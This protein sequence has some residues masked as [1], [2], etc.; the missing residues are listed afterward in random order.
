MND[1]GRQILLM[2]TVMIFNI[3]LYLYPQGIKTIYSM[4]CVQLLTGLALGSRGFSYMSCG[5]RRR[6]A[7]GGHGFC[8]MSCGVRRIL[9]WSGHGFSS[10]SCEVRRG[11]AWSCHGFC[12]VGGVE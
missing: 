6:L 8:F 5:M 7:W 9:A 11:L 2:R 12:F 10:M 3:V 4:W 1:V